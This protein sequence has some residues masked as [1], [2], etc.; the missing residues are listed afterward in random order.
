MVVVIVM[1]DLGTNFMCV[2][3]YVVACVWFVCVVVG[4]RGGVLI[5]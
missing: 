5:I 4:R 2:V 3:V 1:L